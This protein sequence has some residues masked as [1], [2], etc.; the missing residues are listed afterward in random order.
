M[1]IKSKF[2]NYIANYQHSILRKQ[3]NYFILA[4]KQSG[5]LLKTVTNTCHHFPWHDAVSLLQHVFCCI[6]LIFHAILILESFTHTCSSGTSLKMK[7]GN[8]QCLFDTPRRVM[9]NKEMMSEYLDHKNNC[10]CPIIAQSKPQ[11]KY[12]LKR[13][14]TIIAQAKLYIFKFS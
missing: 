6:L 1:K 5:I 8:K 10:V 13:I 14:C 11:L 3:G 9:V 4:F 7:K 2:L 12:S